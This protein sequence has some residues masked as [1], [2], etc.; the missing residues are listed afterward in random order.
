MRSLAIFSTRRFLPV[1]VL[2]CSLFPLFGCSRSGKVE[3]ALVAQISR[4]CAGQA[5][6]RIR[7]DQATSFDWDKM[8]AFKYTAT[9]Q[10]REHALGMKD[11][12]Y[13][14][15]ERQIVFLK[16]GKIVHQESEPTNVEHPVKNE[17]V[18]DIPDAVAFKSY[19]RGTEFT[20]DRL[21]GKLGPYFQLREAR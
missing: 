9:E 6:C 7:I 12:G 17:V 18:F 8:Y 5:S 1:A 10:D 3:T 2:G 14:D 13:R 19:S 20:V 16:D 11:I 4:A 15:L 21:N